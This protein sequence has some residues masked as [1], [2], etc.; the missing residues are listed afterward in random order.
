MTFFSLIILHSNAKACL[1]QVRR[2]QAGGGSSV[3]YRGFPVLWSRRRDLLTQRKEHFVLAEYI[4][5]TASFADFWATV[6]VHQA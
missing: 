6:G 2:W 1:A 5:F 4:S 3:H